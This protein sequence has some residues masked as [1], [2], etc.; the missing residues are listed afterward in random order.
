MFKT[1]LQSLYGNY[2]IS[3]F[4]VEDHTII[5]KT[6]SNWFS[7]TDADIY[8]KLVGTEGETPFELVTAGGR[9]ADEAETGR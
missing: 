3:Y 9:I 2:L 7:G 6:S 8:L 4:V 1:L 5:V